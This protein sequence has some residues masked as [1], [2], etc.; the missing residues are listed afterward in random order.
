[1]SKRKIRSSQDRIEQQLDLFG[2]TTEQYK[3]PKDKKVYLIELFAGV[4]SQH[5]ALS[6]LLGDRLVSWK[7]C[8][9]TYSSIVA[10]N[11]VNIHDYTNYAENKTKEELIDRIRGISVDEVKPLTEEQLQK[12]NIEWLRNAYNNCVA[13]H[14]LINVVEAKAKD[15]ELEKCLDGVVILCYSFPCQDISMAGRLAGYDEDSQSR[16]SMLWQVRRILK[17]M[18]ELG[19][20]PKILMLENVPQVCGSRNLDNWKKWLKELETLGYTSEYSFLNAADYGVAQNR[21]RCF[22]ISLYQEPKGSYTFP[23]K[24]HLKYTL[25]N[26]CKEAVDKKYYLSK[27]MIRGMINTKFHQYQLKN[28]IQNLNGVSDTL[29]TATGERCPHCIP[30]SNNTELGYLLAEVG[31]GIDCSGRM[32]HHRGTVQKGV[33]QTIN[34]S[35]TD[36]GGF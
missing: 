8:E 14:N 7:I 13:T 6:V 24:L 28:S 23:R 3:I 4:G 32:K 17:E 26:Y 1:M 35:G 27:K 10:Y 20:M 12:K 25:R 22:L 36:G 18:K 29:T 33:C 34:C 2:S 21:E 30:I 31:D 9:W 19:D 15:F 16:S 11:S 5:R